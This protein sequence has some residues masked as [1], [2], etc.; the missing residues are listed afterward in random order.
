MRFEES[1]ARPAGHDRASVVQ[2]PW[3]DGFDSGREDLCDSMPDLTAARRRTRR[4]GTTE[5]C[6]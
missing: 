2:I 5:A 3:A 6:S 4:S 1:L